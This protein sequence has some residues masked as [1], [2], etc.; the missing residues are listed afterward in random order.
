MILKLWHGMKTNYPEKLIQNQILAQLKLRKINGDIIWYQRLMAEDDP[1]CPAGTPDIVSVVNCKDGNI[2]LLFIEVKRE[3]VKKL[4]YEQRIFFDE[5]LGKP[6]TL[7]VLIND[8]TQLW[9]AIKKAR[10]L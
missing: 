2:A 3:N 7:C 10:A 6:M 5:M 4:R 8:V 1:C 9:P